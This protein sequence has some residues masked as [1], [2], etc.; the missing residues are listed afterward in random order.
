MRGG[1]LAPG[2]GGGVT[3]RNLN[4]IQVGALL[5]SASYGIGFLFGSGEMAL[6]NGMGGA[7]YGLA[8][9][10]GMLLL[11]AFAARLW[12][13]G[14]PI[15][16]WF[17]Q[18]YGPGLRSSVALLS[19]IWM[20][21][22]LAAQ[23]HGGV[24]IVK[25]LGMGSLAAYALVLF[26]IYAAS[27]INLRAA[28]TVFSFFLLAS[29]LVLAYA[30]LSTHGGAL[31]ARGPA[32]FLDD[33]G[34]FPPNALL[35]ITVAIVALVCTGADYHQFV[36]AA[37]RPGS[38][39]L[40]CVIAGVCLAAVSFLPAA[41]ALGLQQ[42]GGLAGLQD[43]K[44]VIPF[45][46]A[47]A[48]SPLGAA[49]GKILLLG[50]SAAALG[51][52]AAILRAMTSAL[53]SATTRFGTSESPWLALC[54][55]SIGAAL[56]ARG[57]GIVATMVS[58]NIVYIGSVGAL[59]VALLAGWKLTPHPALRTMAAGVIA[60]LVVYVMS[61][62]GRLEGNGDFLSLAAGLLVSG[63]WLLAER[64]RGIPFARARDS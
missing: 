34:T 60:S 56:A 39:V 27:R 28:S 26:S 19:V 20:A 5:V 23:I 14:L 62:T 30:L 59:F 54:A 32:L 21:G 9:A 61:W 15:W 6:T 53:S 22:V 49:A 10:A 8:T 18:A 41:V 51:S 24:A 63:V 25:L 48:A 2:A 38:A 46:L 17:G 31:Y 3:A 42:S 45:A 44:Q 55:L 58:V 35:A 12:R 1:K 52:G 43:A 37:K 47:R 50:L 13:A 64:S 29:G 16:D 7:L 40:G 36:L 4:A 33:L 11:S 57:Q